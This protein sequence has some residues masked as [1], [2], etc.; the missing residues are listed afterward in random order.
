MCDSELKS[1]QDGS[2]LKFV[3]TGRSAEAVEFD[4][5]VQTPWFSGRAPAST[6]FNGSP[7]SMFN[8]MAGAWRG[9]AGQKSW[10]DLEARVSLA[11]ES[12]AT[13]HV[14]LTVELKGQDYDSNLRVVLWYEAGQLE[15]MAGAVRELLG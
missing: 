2:I 8:A 5:F 4:V 14:R 1:P 15:A 7:S 12:D 3:V 13:G 9:W 6:Y 10:Q 11:G